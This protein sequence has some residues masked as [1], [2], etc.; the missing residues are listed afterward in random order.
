AADATEAARAAHDARRDLAGRNVEMAR[1]AEQAQAEAA[2]AEQVRA[3]AAQARAD[4]A[5][6]GAALA[7]AQREA[8]AQ[9]EAA[10]TAAANE[11]RL[12][13]RHQAEQEAHRR[14]IGEYQAAVREL[15][16]ASHTIATL[17]REREIILSSTI[18]RATAP[19]RRLGRAMPEE[20]RRSLRSGLRGLMGAPA[21]A[22]PASPAAP[23]AAPAAAS[24]VVAPR[25]AGGIVVVS[26]EPDIPGHVYRARRLAEAFAHP[27][28]AHRPVSCLR[29]EEAAAAT[30]VLRDAALVV[31]WRAVACPET[32]AVIAAARAGGA[33]IAYDIDDLM[34]VPEI[35]TVQM[36]DG[37]RTQNLNEQET[38]DYFRRVRSVI[39][40]VDLCVCATEELAHHVRGMRVPAFVLPNG[41]DA[42]TLAASRLAAR[43]RAAV[44]QDGLIRIGYAAGTRTH[45]RDFAVAAPALARILAA[46]PTCRL[47]LFRHA[48]EDTALLDATEFPELAAFADQIEWRAKVDLAGLPAEMARFDIN[49]APLEVG[50]PFCEA[51]SELKF[52]EAALAGVVSVVSPTGPMRRILRDRE[53][54]MLADSPDSWFACL[55]ELI[56]DPPLRARL[57]AAALREV[58]WSRGPERRA[59]LALALADQLAGGTQGARAF[60]LELRRAADPAPEFDIPEAETIFAVDTLGEAAVTVVV[61]LYNYA[62]YVTDALDSVAAQTLSPLDL[63]IV[64][65]CSTDHSLEVAKAWA[66]AQSARFNRILVLRNRVN[67]GLARTRNTGFAAAETAAV[68]PLDA[69]NR[70]LPDCLAALASAMA[71]E[72]AAFAYPKLQCFGDSDHLISDLPFSPARFVAGNYIDAMALVSKAAWAA[73]GGYAHIRFGWEDYDFWCRLVARGQFGVHVPKVLGEYRFHQRSM[74]RTT[75]DVGGNKAKVVAQLEQRHPWLAIQDR[76]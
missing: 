35:A 73:V 39:E 55:S 48:G 60:E 57:A 14:A 37:I 76:M 46:H 10:R 23:A 43:R 27:A 32:S 47:V 70:L 52:Y 30:G 31:I 49:I 71:R 19:L 6:A 4:A 62:H 33:K 9:S 53:T 29:Q 3:D 58:L 51:K 26:G 75:T 11:A 68:L 5:E 65:D 16:L 2:R 22:V 64:D 63:I 20:M 21:R 72:A 25:A 66:Q 34:F 44:P 61:P 56:A 40:Q 17:R 74:L 50:N 24:A 1:L 69:D 45:Q 12:L 13:A 15:T 28:F 18:W 41:F 42:A 67:S 59:E 38:A 7:E 54:G 8:A 36:I